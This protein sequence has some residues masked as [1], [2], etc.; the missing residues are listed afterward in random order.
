MRLLDRP[1]S[2]RTRP[3]ER[4]LGVL[5]GVLL[6]AAFTGIAAAPL[7]SGAAPATHPALASACAA[8][9]CAPM[10]P[11]ETEVPAGYAWVHLHHPSPE[12]PPA[13]TEG[14][15]A[16]DPAGG[17]VLLFGGC[18]A[19]TCPLG[20]TW[21]YSGGI[22]TNL[23][24][25][26]SVS[27]P[28]RYGATLAYDPSDGGVLLFGGCSTSGA[29]DD[30]WLFRAGNWSELTPTASWPAAR[31]GATSAEDPALDGVAIY[32][33]SA[34][35]GSRLSD[36]WLYANS[37]FTLLSAGGAGAPAARA[38]ASITFDPTL[39]HLVLFGGE[40]P[41]GSFVAGT[42]TFTGAAW[43]EVASEASE[44]SPR[45][46]ASFAYDPT[47]LGDL[48]FGGLSN[49]GILGDTWLLNDGVWTNISAQIPHPPSPRASAAT[50]FDATDGYLLVE[51]GVTPGGGVR[52]DTWALV[53]PLTAAVVVPYGSVAPGELLR[54]A[55]AVEGGVP[56]YRYNWSFGDGT[57]LLRGSA[58]THSYSSAGEYTVSLEVS[59]LRNVLAWSNVTV[60]VAAS[61]L[62][63]LLSVTPGS[64]VAGS[65]ISLAATPSG[66]TP[67]YT[68]HWTGLPEG[69]SPGAAAS[70]TCR[71]G[72]PGEYSIGISVV[73]SA[74]ATASAG[75]TLSVDPAGPLASSES[76][77]SGALLAYDRY[78]WILVPPLA[79]AVAWAAYASYVSY[80]GTRNLPPL[81]TP[82][83]RPECYVPPEWS[84]TPPAFA[85][86][87]T[88]PGS[89]RALPP[90]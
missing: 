57:P 71:P 35:N 15:M 45:S 50:A 11:A 85:S 8:A 13:R 10:R 51:G 40:G 70:L 24:P 88:A 52:N 77:T 7:A 44:P 21:W 54:F 69:C 59:D 64:V 46:N 4:R 36:L 1:D 80:R 9:S 33:G 90:R 65:S 14:A 16:S 60:E 73:D 74:G 49:D 12:L 76:P 58:P 81:P 66:G 75:A 79:I 48:L 22:W 67:P 6:F 37:T 55:A 20:D 86:G 87:G 26:L 82:P 83:E 18:G 89:D 39:G 32:G 17:G 27:P 47:L 63:V 72:G 84:E 68:L 61:P 53:R 5:T 23:T 19:S 38:G 29:L 62:A 3:A 2:R 31:C 56:P 78:G 42:W 43:L 30:A 28:A 41:N 25:G 34:S